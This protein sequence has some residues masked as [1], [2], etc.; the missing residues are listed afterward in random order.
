MSTKHSSEG[1]SDESKRELREKILRLKKERNAYIVVHN[2]Q[3]PEVQDIAD[4]LGDSLGLSK[5]A[6]GTG[7]DVVVFCGVDFMA[8]SAKI[9]NPKKTVLLPV[10]EADC[11][12]S[13]M[14][15]VEALRQKKKEYRGI[16]R[17]GRLDNRNGR[18]KQEK[19]RQR[20][21]NLCH[22]CGR[23]DPV[24]AIPPRSEIPRPH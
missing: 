12:M 10:R 1:Q 20:Q 24:R 16:G 4:I 2:Y 21:G 5:A 23:K 15:T 7:A 19:L 18:A 8:E 6:I 13:R 3:L 14:L 22:A 9:L 11:P 17:E